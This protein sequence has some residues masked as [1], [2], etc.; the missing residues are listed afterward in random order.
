MPHGLG[1]GK[2]LYLADDRRPAF[3]KASA[4]AMAPADRTAGR[5]M[6]DV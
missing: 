6:T 3:A 5:L 2:G 4:Y 1:K